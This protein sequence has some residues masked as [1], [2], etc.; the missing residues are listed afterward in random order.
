LTNDLSI[1]H[2]NKKLSYRKQIARQ[3][4]TQYVEGIYSNFVTLKSRLWVTQGH[5]KWHHSINR[6]RVPISVPRRYVVSFARYIVMDLK[7]R[8]TRLCLASRRCDPV[9]ISRRCSILIKWIDWVDVWWRIVTILHWAVSIQYRNVT[10][11]QNCY[12]SIA[13]QRAAR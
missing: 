2:I 6:I 5:R 11:R 7:S 9:G 4:G 3:L 10:D 1:S 12:I 8:N 13:C